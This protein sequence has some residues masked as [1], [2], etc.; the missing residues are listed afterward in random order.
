MRIEKVPKVLA[1]IPDGN[2]RW[3]KSHRLNFIRGYSVGVKKFIEFSDWCREYGVRNIIV[4]AFSTE[5]FSRPKIEQ[6]ALFN[7]YRKV[8]HDRKLIDKLHKNRTRFRIVGNRSL[9]PKDLVSALHRIEIETGAYKNRVINML[10]AY[11]GRDDILHAAKKVVDEAVRSKVGDVNEALFR[12]CLISRDV[13]DIDLVIRT[14]GE[15]RLSGFMPWQAVYSELHFSKK[16]WP[17]F[18]KLDLEGALEDY[19][20]RQRRFGS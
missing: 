10:I 11:G 1:L 12:A 9:L 2:R 20:N 4:W 18:T 8:A 5:N 13:P 6:D 14:S 3:A 15:E 17:D 7:I 16:L 19:S